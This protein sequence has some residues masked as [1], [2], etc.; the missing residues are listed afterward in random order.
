MAERSLGGSSSL[1][2][3]AEGHRSL[4]FYGVPC[5]FIIRFLPE[6]Y[7]GVKLTN[8]PSS[9]VVISPL[10]TLGWAH[11]KSFEQAGGHGPSFVVFTLRFANLLQA[12]SG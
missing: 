8:R 6:Q 10:R 3:M 12:R 5:K 4:G 1:S 2:A 11:E 7:F 9:E